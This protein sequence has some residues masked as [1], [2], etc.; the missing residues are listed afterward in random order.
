MKETKLEYFFNDIERKDV[1]DI[2]KKIEDGVD[3]VKNLEN[4]KCKLQK[5]IDYLPSLTAN[6]KISI[7][8]NSDETRK[9]A[10]EEF[11]EI[12]GTPLLVYKDHEL[13]EEVLK[14]YGKRFKIFSAVRI[15]GI[16][17]VVDK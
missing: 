5:R 9:K 12:S 13:V 11:F 2:T 6:Y 16:R 7:K 14:S 1:P 3:K 17:I 4:L 15:L 8:C 10:L